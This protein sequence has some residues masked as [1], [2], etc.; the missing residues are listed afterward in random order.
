MLR[1]LILF[2]I[3]L[4]LA[5]FYWAREN[6]FDREVWSHPKA[7]GSYDP[8]LL[9]SELENTHT[10]DTED[11]VDELEI[12]RQLMCFSIGPFD[13]SDSSDKMYDVLFDL[14]IQAKQRIVNER[15]PK[16]YWVYL[17]SKNSKSKAE[18]TVAF[19][20]ENNVDETYIWL[21]APHRYAVSLGLFSKLS[22]ARMKLAE[23]EKLDLDPEMEVRYIEI[24]QFWVDYQHD[25]DTSQ[26]E[27]F[28]ELFR[29]N[30]RLLIIESNCT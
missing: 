29:E 11:V 12:N 10:N 26:P 20:S 9:L 16:S 17:P 5:F 14:G 18:E 3:F 23:I 24:T 28:E 15:Q 19:L 21:D 2:V 1:T 30:Q 4:N 6:N 8:I 27:K 7:I 13:D 25:T 22:T